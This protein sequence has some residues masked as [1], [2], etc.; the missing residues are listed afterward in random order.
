MPKAAGSE[1][2][3]LAPSETPIA[4]RAIRPQAP[5]A[6][7][8][9]ATASGEKNGKLKLPPASPAETLPVPPPSTP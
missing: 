7:N 6:V 1:I 2:K 9:V 5:I 4:W 3:R 8:S